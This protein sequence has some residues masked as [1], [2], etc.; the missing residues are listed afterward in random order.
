M[1]SKTP[2]PVV[3][4]PAWERRP[5]GEEIAK[6]YPLAAATDG[7][8]GSA[9]LRCAVTS[10]GRVEQCLIQSE[11]PPGSGFGQAAAAMAP[12]FRMKPMTVN[13]QAVDGGTV[14]LPIRF[15]LPPER[16]SQTDGAGGGIAGALLQVAM[17]AAV[18][19]WLLTRL[20]V[21]PILAF[22][23]SPP[24]D[25]SRIRA[26]LE[27]ISGAA[28]PARKVLDITHLGGTLPSRH[29]DPQRRYRVTLARPDGA[30][31]RRIVMI[32]VALFGEG[33]MTLERPD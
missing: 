10:A 33:Q 31:E 26:N 16:E 23:T 11:T 8:E 14:R 24:A 12:L 32:T 4:P 6:Y 1:D 28:G 9:I 2:P 5:T 7:V 13:G 17:I 29:S 3:T 27:G 18:L 25:L 20:V 22:R 30:T 15:L 21:K 19:G